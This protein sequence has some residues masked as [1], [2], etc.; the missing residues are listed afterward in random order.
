MKKH[1][2][3][4]LLILLIL[5]PVSLLALMMFYSTHEVPG[6]KI[7]VTIPEGQSAAQIGKLLSESG[8]P[9]S[10]EI[11]SLAALLT[12]VDKRLDSGTYEIGPDVSLAGLL[13]ML[14]KGRG[15]SIHVTIPEGSDIDGVTRR[16]SQNLGLD[17]TVLRELAEEPAFVDSLVPG[18]RSLE[19]FLYPDTYLIPADITERGAL[20]LMVERFNEIFDDSLRELAEKNGLS[21]YS[22]V[23]L[24]SIIEKEAKVPM[25]RKIISGV[26]HNRLKLGRPIESCA[27]IRYLLHKPTEPLT[28]GD[29]EVPSA[30]NTYLNPGLPP[31]P[32]CNPGRASLEAAV[33]PA[34]VGYLYFVAKGDGSHIFSKDLSEHNLAKK[35]LKEEQSRQ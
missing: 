18:R 24:A 8:V 29:L 34:E 15:Y 6:G 7:L 4:P 32:I 33:S 10:P 20:R 26:F 25:E 35:K 22:S 1:L 11:F 5:V 3:V 27:T 14:R 23:I 13:D 28:Y 9:V 16:L 19:G 2:L 21:Y 12:G 30:Y 31:A 17:E